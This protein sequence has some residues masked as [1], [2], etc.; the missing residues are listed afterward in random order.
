MKSCGRIPG[1]DLLSELSKRLEEAVFISVDVV[2][3]GVDAK[4][5]GPCRRTIRHE[6]AT[7]QTEHRKEMQQSVTGLRN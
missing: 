5:T 1:I 4:I 6:I 7:Q 2:S 3:R